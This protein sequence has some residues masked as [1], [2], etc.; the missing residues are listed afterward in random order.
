MGANKNQSIDVLMFPWLGY[1][2]ITPYLELAK[3]LTSRGFNIYLCSTPATF[4]CVDKKITKNQSESI[5]LVPLFLP[6]LPG[7]PPELHTTNGLPSHLMPRLKEAFDLS[8]NDFS[9]ILKQLKPHLLIY[10]VIQPWA[11]L[12]AKEHN[13]PAVEFITSSSTMTSFMFHC[14]RKPWIEF[15]FQNI[16]FRDYEY[17]DLKRLLECDP[18]ER[19]GASEGVER[20][21]KI[22]LIKGFKDIE[23]KYIDYVSSLFGKKFVLVG[24]LVQEPIPDE[25]EDDSSGL[26]SWLD[27]KERKSTVFVSFG[28][29][30]FLTKEDFDEIAYGLELSKINFIWVV[31]FP[32]GANGH[33]N[34]LLEK[35]LPR[36]FLESV[37]DRG[38]I[39][40]GWAP[41]TRILGH[42]SIGVPIHHDQPIN[43]R[44][45]EE[46]GV[47][48][49]VLRD[50]NKRLSGER[51]AAV[52]KQVVMEDC[53]E[54]VRQKAAEMRQKL[55]SKGDQ[56][57]DEVVKE[58]VMVCNNS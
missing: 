46:V 23:G 17:S 50:R 29:E 18:T 44:L 37:G 27:M 6:P 41:Q 5:K 3:K 24:P 31:R 9:N 35:T 20:S 34:G 39:L 19:D 57:I 54:V 48:V 56:E 55:K 15:P 33:I 10:D 1:G 42:E 36:G 32:K 22:V 11:P 25:K 52:I 26:F 45:V 13:I 16:Y 8:V 30:Y 53:G 51:L 58:L 49:E 14:F 47:G 28:S 43:A 40:E 21:C 38:K 7:L 2:H 12:V 4:S